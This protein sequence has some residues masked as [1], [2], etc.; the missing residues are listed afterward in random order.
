MMNSPEFSNNKSNKMFDINNEV[1]EKSEH[2]SNQPSETFTFRNDQKNQF[3][4]LSFYESFHTSSQ[5][6]SETSEKYSANEKIQIPPPKKEEINRKKLNKTNEIKINNIRLKDINIRN[7]K[8]NKSD[9]IDINYK[10]EINKSPNFIQKK[11]NEIKRKSSS[12]SQKKN[13]L[14]LFKN[15]FSINTSK[16]NMVPQLD[17]KK[18]LLINQVL[19]NKDSI[20]ISTSKYRANV[21]NPLNL[22]KRTENNS[23]KNSL[24]ES[25]RNNEYRPSLSEISAK[26]IHGKTLDE[27]MDIYLAN[28]DSLNKSIQ[29]YMEKQDNTMQAIVQN[30]K[31]TMQ[32][33]QVVTQNQKDIKNLMKK[34][35]GYMENQKEIYQALMFNLQ[36]LSGDVKNL[37][38]NK[39]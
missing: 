28:Q 7:K 24:N 9:L 11:I 25:I 23:A 13:K 27:K 8:G 32:F 31:N 3:N 18:K 2:N 14:K 29:T 19:P 15:S 20:S 33:M 16:K 36:Q 1:K 21:K 37:K 6:E 39:K 35:D 22:K 10:T 30:Q 26:K 12:K 17:S 4:N 5:K 34:Q 38:K